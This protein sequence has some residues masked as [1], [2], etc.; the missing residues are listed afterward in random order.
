MTTRYLVSFSSPMAAA[1]S[2]DTGRFKLRAVGLRS[3]ADSWR[4]RPTEG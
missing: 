2:P 3:L 1:L 4:V